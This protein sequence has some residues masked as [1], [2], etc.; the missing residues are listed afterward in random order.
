VTVRDVRV[1]RLPPWVRPG[2]LA[3]A[4]VVLAG[5]VLAALAPGDLASPTT[6]A[7]VDGTG[8]RPDIV[9]VVTD[10]QR[11]D[12]VAE[13]PNV[14][15]L[16]VAE[17]R[18]FTNAMVPTSLCCPSRSS[19]LTGLYAHHTRVF[20]NG[21][22]GGPQFG[23]YPQFRRRGLEYRTVALALSRRGY[24]TGFFGKYLNHFARTTTTGYVPPGWD[25]FV[26]FRL[27]RHAYY[28]YELTDGSRFGSRP[29]DYST[30]VLARRATRYVEHAPRNRPMFLMLAPYGPHAP[31]TPA[32]R[33]LAAA[34]EL[35]LP[36]A[37]SMLPGGAAAALPHW[38]RSRQGDAQVV[39]D[40]RVGQ[41]RTLLSVDDAVRS[42]VAAL[43][44][45]GRLH[46]T[47]FVL[48]SDNGLM[49]GEHGLVGKDNPYDAATRVPMVIRW[50]GHVPAGT[51]D[52][53]L[54]L[55]LDVAPTLATA[56]GTS[57]TTDGL[58]L[59]GQATRRGFPL[60]AATGY[61]GR[62]A[63]CGWRST[64]WLYVH[65]ADGTTELYDY[66]SDPGE[67]HNLAGDPAYAGTLG[68]LRDRAV[69]GGSPEPPGFD[70]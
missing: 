52:D 20:T 26:A 28:D 67:L 14:Q 22:L 32:P 35:G 13:M 25:R 15:R 63:Y 48:L 30:D 31:F 16:L 65:Y 55:N 53:R 5:L 33:H 47:L 40:T 41:A 42:V 23:G 43:R 4:A 27:G 70:W 69:R 64:R 29:Q 50:D 58:D 46:N 54:A 11:A 66:R 18:Q 3:V 57:M 59:L 8:P 17:G 7:V 68:R 45:T 38:Q 37:P 19:I 44:R 24:H 62:P 36:P 39:T 49:T 60:E 2:R 9:L 21:D 61:Q 10:D 6:D 56:A 34:V 1:P 12:T 51:V